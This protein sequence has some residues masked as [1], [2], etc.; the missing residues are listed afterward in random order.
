MEVSVEYHTT[1]KKTEIMKLV[2]MGRIGKTIMFMITQ[3]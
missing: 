2:E 1:V 3:S